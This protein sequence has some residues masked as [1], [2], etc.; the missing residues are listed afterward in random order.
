MNE[1]TK[2][3]IRLLDKHGIKFKCDDYLYLEDIFSHSCCYDIVRLGY[4][5]FRPDF[6]SINKFDIFCKLLRGS[7]SRVFPSIILIHEN[8]LNHHYK[9]N[10][11]ETILDDTEYLFIVF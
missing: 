7:V 4:K 5:A 2:I 1:S 9:I 8:N 10:N 3:M 6:S 11:L